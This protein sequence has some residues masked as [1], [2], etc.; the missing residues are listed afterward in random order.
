MCIVR[1]C[2]VVQHNP[3]FLMT[4]CGNAAVPRLT[5]VCSMLRVDTVQAWRKYSD[6]LLPVPHG[7]YTCDKNK[8]CMKLL[9]GMSGIN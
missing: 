7:K 2:V 6:R 5:C 8:F 4:A 9:S 1:M 3:W